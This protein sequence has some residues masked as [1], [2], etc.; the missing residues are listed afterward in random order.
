MASNHVVTTAADPKGVTE[1]LVSVASIRLKV[2]RFDIDP[3]TARAHSTTLRVASVLVI[4][5]EQF[6]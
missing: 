6:D 1:P 2:L 4:Y 5:G 3:G